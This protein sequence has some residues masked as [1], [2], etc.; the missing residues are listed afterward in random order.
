MHRIREGVHVR[1]C[2][3]MSLTH[4][5]RLDGFALEGLAAPGIH[6]VPILPAAPACLALP[7]MFTAAVYIVIFKRAIPSN[8]GNTNV[9]VLQISPEMWKEYLVS[10][11]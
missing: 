11:E 8:K 3:L 4:F 5:V 2:E 10:W 6:K 1:K 7:C 9:P